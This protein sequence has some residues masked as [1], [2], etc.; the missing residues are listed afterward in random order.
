MA[1]AQGRTIPN[2]QWGDFF[3]RLTRD[4]EGADA[5]IELMAPD[6]QPELLAFGQPLVEVRC[7]TSVTVVLGDGVE[8]MVEHATGVSVEQDNAGL[9]L[10]VMIQAAG[11]PPARLT[12]ARGKQRA[13]GDPSLSG[14]GVAGVDP[15]FVGGSAGAS[16]GSTGAGNGHMAAGIGDDYGPQITFG[17][18]DDMG[19]VAS[20]GGGSIGDVDLSGRQSYDITAD[21]YGGGAEELLDQ[22]GAGGGHTGPSSETAGSGAASYT[23]REGGNSAQMG[24]H[25]PKIVDGGGDQGVVDL[26]IDSIE[27]TQLDPANDDTDP[28]VE[29]EV[30]AQAERDIDDLADEHPELGNSPRRRREGDE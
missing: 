10:I 5:T 17:T 18:T 2:E 24:H 26:T 19:G 3:D 16:G 22:T 12:L 6:D 8:H 23:T 20:V 25:K 13:V 1:R 29:G 30:G 21:V 7:D 27:G 15:A 9:G 28:Y 14:A 11:G 4:Y